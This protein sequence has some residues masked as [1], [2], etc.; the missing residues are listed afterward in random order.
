MP[1]DISHSKKDLV[2]IKPARSSKAE[3]IINDVKKIIINENCSSLILD[4]SSFNLFDS[5]RVGTIIA[6]Y[7]FVQFMNGKI[8]IVVQDSLAKKTI[9][10]FK[11]RNATVVISREKQAIYNIA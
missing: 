5:I 2:S 7:H 9:E 3:K 10:N 6:T 8:Y 11:L 4:L 1:I